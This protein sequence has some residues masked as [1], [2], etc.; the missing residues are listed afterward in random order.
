MVQWGMDSS[1]AAFEALLAAIDAELAGLPHGTAQGERDAQRHRVARL[2]LEADRIEA[3]LHSRVTSQPVTYGQASF[4]AECGEPA[5]C[6]T[7]RRLVEA[8]PPPRAR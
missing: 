4:C 6:P 8:H 3:E 1:S 5:P 7:V 2:R